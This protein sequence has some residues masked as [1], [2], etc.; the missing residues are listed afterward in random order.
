[1]GIVEAMANSICS[2]L[3]AR[4]GDVRVWL[5]SYRAW[6]VNISN[7]WPYASANSFQTYV[8]V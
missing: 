1:M 7:N 4:Q 8:N 2:E 3:G 5:V 6:V